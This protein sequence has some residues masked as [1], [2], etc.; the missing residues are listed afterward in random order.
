MKICSRR[1]DE[2]LEN[3]KKDIINLIDKIKATTE[4]LSK[5]SVLCGWCEFKSMCPKFGGKIEEQRHPGAY[6]KE[7]REPL[8]GLEKY[9]EKIFTEGKN[10]DIYPTISKYVRD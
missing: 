1:T 4:F 9:S 5:K 3:L 8:R 7:V 10:L 2:Q 6:T